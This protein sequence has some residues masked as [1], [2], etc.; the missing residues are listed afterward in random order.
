MS[1]NRKY[2]EK[3]QTETLNKDMGQIWVKYLLPSERTFK[4]LKISSFFEMKK[5]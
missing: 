3:K 4:T 5:S 2:A 1:E